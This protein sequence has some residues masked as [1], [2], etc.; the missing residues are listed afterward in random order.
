M[1][2]RVV[3]GISSVLFIIGFVNSAASAIKIKK[4]YKPPHFQIALAPAAH[5][6]V[7][8]NS[9]ALLVNVYPVPKNKRIYVHSSLYTQSN[10]RFIRLNKL[11]EGQ[12]HL[13]PQETGK[14]TIKVS[15]YS[16]KKWQS[17]II[18][19]VVQAIATHI[20]VKILPSPYGIKSNRVV[21]L[22]IYVYPAP[23]KSFI[24]VSSLTGNKLIK[25]CRKVQLKNGYAVCLLEP[26]IGQN[27]IA[28][29]FRHQNYES[30]QR[31]LNF[32]IEKN[33]KI[34]MPPT[35]D[36]KLP[37]SINGQ[38]NKIMSISFAIVGTSNMNID[39]APSNAQLKVYGSAKQPSKID[40]QIQLSKTAVDI[41]LQ[42]AQKNG[43]W[44]GPITIVASGKTMHYV[45][46]SPLSISDT[47]LHGIARTG[48]TKSASTLYW[49]IVR[50]PSIKKKYPS[51]VRK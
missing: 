14:D 25:N 44:T 49:E 47:L 27:K 1:L 17:R 38:I 46:T 24:D 10:C 34:L 41:H 26:T 7:V 8:D 37:S 13:L 18:H 40:A 4:P 11:G 45:E 16:K 20:T 48:E 2:R 42:R 39:G 30:S 5:A 6:S 50:T 22:S 33:Y 9:V 32:F 51:Y 31:A 23:K 43:S 12:C 3:I 21:P 36:V 35:P 28:V 19:H 29:T 15:V